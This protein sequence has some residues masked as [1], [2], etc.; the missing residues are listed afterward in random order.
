MANELTRDQ[1]RGLEAATK[2]VQKSAEVVR[3]MREWWK[4][5]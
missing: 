3:S 2:Q 1:M 5:C 4:L